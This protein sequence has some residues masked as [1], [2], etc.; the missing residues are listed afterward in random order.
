MY[1]ESWPRLYK[2]AEL[3]SNLETIAN[4]IF[5]LTAVAACTEVIN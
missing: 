3:G 2:I 1:H 4:G 5:E